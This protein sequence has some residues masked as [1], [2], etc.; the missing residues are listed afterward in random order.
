MSIYQNTT[1]LFATLMQYSTEPIPSPEI[2]D[3]SEFKDYLWL[4]PDLE[5]VNYAHIPEPDTIA[6]LCGW[7]IKKTLSLDTSSFRLE[8]PRNFS[9]N[10]ID[11]ADL[12]LAPFG[13]YNA[14][15][16]AIHEI[17]KIIVTKYGPV[18]ELEHA[19]GVLYQVVNPLF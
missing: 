13:E 14:A 15:S 9:P 19:K 7:I 16:N 5:S 11:A 8:P 1:E 12:L 18:L 2:K 10:A 4:L 6:Q 17:F 3:C